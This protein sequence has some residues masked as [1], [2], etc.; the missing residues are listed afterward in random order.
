M[1][2]Y[3]NRGIAY[4]LK[5]LHDRAIADFTQAIALEPDFATAWATTRSTHLCPLGMS[6]SWRRLAAL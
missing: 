1:R 2:K 6:A 3:Y 5:R 4:D